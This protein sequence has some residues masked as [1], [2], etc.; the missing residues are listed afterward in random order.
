MHQDAHDYWEH[1]AWTA[2][3][4]LAAL[5]QAR[6]EWEQD[7]QAQA[8]DESDAI[9]RSIE[10]MEVLLGSPSSGT[11]YLARFGLTILN[12]RGTPLISL[13][14]PHTPDLRGH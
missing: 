12:E 9:L 5:E 1:D 4:E 2:E 11:L 3:M 14:P 10:M 8:Q 7:A 13:L 6:R